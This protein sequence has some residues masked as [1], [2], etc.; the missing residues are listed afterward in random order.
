MNLGSHACWAAVLSDAIVTAFV[1]LSIAR[2]LDGREF[3]VRRR[4]NPGNCV[5]VMP[6]V[7]PGVSHFLV[8]PAAAR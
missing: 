3:A 8:G 7:V 1:V 4:A 6:E 5:A 2:L